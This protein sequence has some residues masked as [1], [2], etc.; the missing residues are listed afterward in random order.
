MSEK[1]YRRSKPVMSLIVFSISLLFA[2]SVF[3]RDLGLIILQE[4]FAVSVALNNDRFTKDDNKSRVVYLG[5]SSGFPYFF[6][7]KFEHLLKRS[8]DMMPSYLLATDFGATFGLYA[9]IKLEK[10]LGNTPIYL[11]GG[12]NCTVIPSGVAAVTTAA[13]RPETVHAFVLSLLTHSSYQKHISFSTSFEVIFNTSIFPDISCV[14][15][16]KIS[17]IRAD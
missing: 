9:T 8:A 1:S 2:H 4:P 11:G 14:P 10:R 15:S 5:I 13:L 7:I 12:Y 17:I 16:V 6:G 3:G